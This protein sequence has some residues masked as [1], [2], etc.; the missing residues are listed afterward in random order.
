ML[1]AYVCFPFH[2]TYNLCLFPI[3]PHRFKVSCNPPLVESLGLWF[4]T[5]N[6]PRSRWESPLPAGGRPFLSGRVRPEILLTRL[7]RPYMVQTTHSVV[8]IAWIDPCG[9]WLSSHL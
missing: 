1:H 8:D 5:H 3:P 9:R 6:V 7:S 2:R 4:P